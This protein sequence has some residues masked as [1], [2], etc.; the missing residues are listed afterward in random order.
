MRA[1][2]LSMLVFLVHEV[3]NSSKHDVISIAPV[4]GE[5]QND[6]VLV[7]VDVVGL[8]KGDVL[9]QHGNLQLLPLGVVVDA[10]FR[11]ISFLLDIVRFHFSFIRLSQGIR[12]RSW[13]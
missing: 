13:Y 6:L 7:V 8:E 11:D 4:F 3:A 2:A 9:L 12:L 10:S 1:V 5:I